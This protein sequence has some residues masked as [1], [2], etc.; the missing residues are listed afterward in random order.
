[1]DPSESKT[2]ALEGFVE[3]SKS[4]KGKACVMLIQQVLKD[5]RIFVVGE[6]LTSENIAALHG[7]EHQPW[8]E[9]LKLCAYG[10]YMDYVAKRE[11]LSLPA[12]GAAETRKLRQLT[13]TSLA[14][15]SN[16][17]EYGGLLRDL[18]LG[19][20][21]ELED[22]I[23]DS[24]YEGLLDGKLDQRHSCFL[25]SYAM[26]RDIGP[27]D[28]DMMLDKLGTWLQSSEAALQTMRVSLEEAES[29]MQEHKKDEEELL[30]ERADKIELI[31]AE[32]AEEESAAGL[33]SRLAGSIIGS[34]IPGRAAQRRKPDLRGPRR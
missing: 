23:I 33:G 11:I 9:M 25:V 13:L 20:V 15:Q 30:K 14:A 7:T 2:G 26:G 8:L 31:K 18:Q 24:C 4:H 28:V 34:M 16:R 3:L 12:L 17:L 32:R 1:M 6:L 29:K 27:T 21:R 5:P 22:L 10:T 19:T